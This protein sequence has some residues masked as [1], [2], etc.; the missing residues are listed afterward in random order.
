[1]KKVVVIIVT[2]NGLQ[3]INECLTSVFNSTIQVDVVVIDNNSSDETVNFIENNFP[4]IILFKQNENLGF[5]KANN[6]GL[7]YA[8]EQNADFVFL[9]N[10]D[11]FVNNN[12]IEELISASKSNLNYG[13]LSPIQLEYSGKRLEKYF[14]KFMFEDKTRS[15]YSDFIVSNPIKEIYDIKFIQAAAWL[16]PK[17]TLLKVGGFDTVFFHYG[18]DDNY[19][20]RVL[21][22]NLKIGVVS[23]SFIRHDGN[24]KSAITEK[25]FTEEYYKKYILSI[26]VKYC[27]INIAFDKIQ[28]N[29]ERKKIY[30]LF[31]LNFVK[32]NFKGTTGTLK[33]LKLFNSN[34]NKINYSR[35]KNKK[36]NTNYLNE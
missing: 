12:S 2:Y 32:L 5:G 18:E 25:S 3:W 15:F 11:A 33:Q 4:K 10:Q 20:H 17:N 6:I 27:N 24:E 36:E 29:K 30:K 8:L 16:I 1:M 9:L 21:F 26:L 28:I 35:N 31:L 22:H 13:I 23:K 34:I 14:H 7:S 19:C